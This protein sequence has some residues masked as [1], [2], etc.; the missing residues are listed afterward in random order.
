IAS[1]VLDPTQFADNPDGVSTAFTLLVN[2]G[3]RTASTRPARLQVNGV[4]GSPDAP[5]VDASVPGVVMI[6]DDKRY[7]DITGYR[8]VPPGEYVVNVLT[9]DGNTV[10]ASFAADVTGTAGT[11][12]TVLASGFLDPSQ[13]QNGPA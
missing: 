3:A 11:T 2:D 12:M 10:V 8:N 1:G 7:T 4:H 5:T 6:A 9:A 13:N